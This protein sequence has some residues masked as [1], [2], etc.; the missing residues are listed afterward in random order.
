VQL[1]FHRTMCLEAGEYVEGSSEKTLQN[2]D[3]YGSKAAGKRLLKMLRLGS[4]VH[5][6]MALQKMTGS[7]KLDA[8]ALLEYFKPLHDWLVAENKRTGAYIGW[9]DDGADLC[10]N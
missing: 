2:C 3:I 10:Q 8:G 4:S 1:Q 9:K 5:W 7:E 6:S